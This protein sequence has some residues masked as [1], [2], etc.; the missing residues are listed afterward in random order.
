MSFEKSNLNPETKKYRD[1]L[2]EELKK[3]R[4]QDI[5]DG[6]T[7]AEKMLQEEKQT[8]GY[9]EADKEQKQ[10]REE[11]INIKNQEKDVDKFNRIKEK[12]VRQLF[13]PCLEILKFEEG[14]SIPVGSESIFSSDMNIKVEADFKNF[15]NFLKETHDFANRHDLAKTRNF[16]DSYETEIDEKIFIKLYAFTKI[17]E[18]RYLDNIGNHENRMNLYNNKEDKQLTL[19]DVF[20]NEAAECAEISALAQKYLQQENISSSYF[21]GFVLWDKNH[22]FSEAHTF[23]IVRE[24]QKFYIYDPTNPINTNLGKFPS[25]YTVDVNFD[26]EMA[27]GK[28]N[29]SLQ[30]IY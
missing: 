29:S 14:D 10:V 13:G 7:K 3:T 15:K 19:S 28:K 12:R 2:A 6:G 9:K 5:K 1:N 16:L 20:N 26:K 22:E 21:S 8:D 18:K 24:N 4:V 25:I 23:I 27:E 17:L 30:I 11:F